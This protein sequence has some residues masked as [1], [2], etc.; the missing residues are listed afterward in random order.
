MVVWVVE[1]QYI[2]SNQ[3]T[4]FVLINAIKFLLF[5]KQV[6][7]IVHETQAILKYSAGDHYS[8]VPFPTLHSKDS[9]RSRSKFAFPL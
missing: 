7:V 2:Q 1:G 5:Q 4:A 8:V 9:G 6:G 3:F